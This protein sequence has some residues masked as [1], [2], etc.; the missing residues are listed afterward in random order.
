MKKY[1]KYIFIVILLLP[2]EICAQQVSKQHFIDI[3]NK[4]VIK[5]KSDTSNL[6]KLKDIKEDD[7]INPEIGRTY[8]CFART[9]S[10][11]ITFSKLEKNVNNNNY[12]LG[13]TIAI[14]LGF[15]WLWGK[16]T[17]LDAD[18]LDIKPDIF[19]GFFVDI[20]PRLEQNGIVTSS[21]L[22]VFLGIDKFGMSLG[23]DY[24]NKCALIG[25]ATTIDFSSLNISNSTIISISEIIKPKK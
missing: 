10:I 23:Y 13:K 8:N 21:S 11:P 25:F 14:G 22:N 12:N 7:Y 18:K 5:Q 6:L 17:F 4:E 20:G 1:N 24:L 16:V 3:F 9:N 2:I 15:S 19:L